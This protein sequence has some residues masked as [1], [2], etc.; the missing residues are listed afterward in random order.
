MPSDP[1]GGHIGSIGSVVPESLP[2]P[3]PGVA[4]VPSK[5]ATFAGTVAA[6]FTPV[7]TVEAAPS[8]NLVSPLNVGFDRNGFCRLLYIL[9][10]A[11]PSYE[12][13]PAVSVMA[14]PPP[15]PPVA[16]SSS[17]AAKCPEGRSSRTGPAKK[18]RLVTKQAPTP[19]PVEP[20]LPIISR[21]EPP[22]EVPDRPTFAAMAARRPI[23]PLVVGVRVQVRG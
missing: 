11:L 3:P 15:P 22:R 18:S 17:D 5:A 23:A 20:V 16:S 21:R 9:A 19:P 13:V 14:P 1:T 4:M 12:Q 10:T 6:P 7:T 8:V 2:L